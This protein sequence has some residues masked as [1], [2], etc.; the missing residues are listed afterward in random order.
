MKLQYL[1]KRVRPDILLPVIFLSSRVTKSTERDWVKL[2][3]VVKYLNGTKDVVMT[4]KPDEGLISI[5]A[6]VDASFA[7]H[8]DFKSHT[9]AVITF[10]QGCIYFKSTKQRLN[11]RSSTEAELVGVSD[12]LTTIIWLR[13]F[14]LDQGYDVGPA[15]LYQDNMSTIAMLSNGSGSNERTRHINIKFFFAHDRIEKGEVVVKYMPTDDMLADMLTKPIQGEKFKLMRNRI[16][17]IN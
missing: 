2:I 16:L 8:H 7:V 3:R 14:L 9:G 15:V 4:L 13:D 10:G 6:F 12:A 17:G 1:A 11:T 5:Y